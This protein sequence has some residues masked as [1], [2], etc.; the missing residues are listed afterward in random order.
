MLFNIDGSKIDWI[1]HGDEYEMWTNRLT[2]EEFQAIKDELNSRVSEGEVHTSSWM[3]GCDWSDTV[4]QPIYDRACGQHEESAAK[5]FGLILW[6]VM[7]DRKGEAW[8]FGRY[9]KDGIPIE[10]LTYFR[11]RDFDHRCTSAD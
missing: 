3:P 2:T 9:Q 11:V 1:P 8:C 7:M 5:C 10:G 4:F 6:K